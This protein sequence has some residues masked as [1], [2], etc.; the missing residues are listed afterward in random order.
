MLLKYH[1]N[2]IRPWYRT[3]PNVRTYTSVSYTHLD[4]YKRQVWYWVYLIYKNKINQCQGFKIIIT[5]DMCKLQTYI[6]MELKSF[7]SMK[8]TMEVIECMNR[9]Y[10]GT[11]KGDIFI[12][13]TNNILWDSEMVSAHQLSILYGLSLIHISS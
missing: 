4:V 10:S 1:V 8:I 6:L 9:M 11:R 13:C 12:F 2:K 5:N 7:K 3:I